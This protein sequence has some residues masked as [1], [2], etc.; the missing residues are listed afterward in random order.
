M[1]KITMKE[2]DERII[3][4]VNKHKG[5]ERIETSSFKNNQYR[6]I[7]Y[8]E[9]GKCLYEVNK[10]Y[11]SEAEATFIFNDEPQ[12]VMLKIKIFETEIWDDDDSK[13]QYVFELVK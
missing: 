4:F 1:R 12:K 10:I 11:E 8:C 5:I 2:H 3:N 7:Y 6:K 13:S 9:D